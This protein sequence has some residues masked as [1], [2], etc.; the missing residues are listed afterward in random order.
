MRD[1]NLKEFL[2]F[3]V[4]YLGLLI[5]IKP[6]NGF[7]SDSLLKIHESYSLV[8]SELHSELLLYPGKAIDPNYEFFLWQGIF[9]FRSADGL[10][11]VF[12]VFLS[13]LYLPLTSWEAFS[14]IP[15]FG[16]LFHLGS[17]WILRNH[18]KLS[19]FWTAFA[20]FGTYVFLM[21]PDASEHPILLFLLLLGITQFFKFEHQGMILAGLLFG[22]GVWLRPETLVFFVSF[23]IAGWI[24]FGRNWLRKSFC[25]SISFSIIVFLFFLFNFWDYHHIFGPRVSENFK[26]DLSVENTIFMRAW[27]ILVGSYAMPGFLLYLPVSAIL[28]GGIFFA[29]SKITSVEK[30]LFYTLCIFIPA[31]A[32]LSPNNGISNWGPRYLGLSLFP[33]AILLSRVWTASDWRI[34]RVSGILNGIG[35]LLIL[36]S[37]LMSLAG[38]LIYRSSIRQVQDTRS[39]AE[40]GHPDI[41]IYS[42]GVLCNSIGTEFFRKIVFCSQAGISK[43]RIE[44]LLNDISESYKGKRLGF[45]SYGEKA[46][47]M[48]SQKK[49]LDSNIRGYFSAVLSGK[50]NRD[51]WL[52][53]FRTRFGE[54]TLE[55]RKIWEYREYIIK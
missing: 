22:L 18:W 29:W 39:V 55:S 36:Y 53:S 19:W 1:K 48:A 7:F 9:T 40:K 34:T 35:M 26:P 41:L 37:F 47:E 8:A 5:W 46:Y 38:I 50:Q 42:D 32:I 17:A 33:F 10:I 21:G 15:F 49:D 27:D 13:V 54:E 12:P 24:S 28:L 45:I 25:F 11:G 4:A 43:A 23:W 51:F 52:D 16:A 20:F 14:L 31:I 2:V 30:I 3:A 6:W 44:K